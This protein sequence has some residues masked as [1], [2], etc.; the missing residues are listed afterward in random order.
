M[1]FSYEAANQSGATIIGEIEA[2]NRHEA[3][4]NLKGRG[5]IVTDIGE[6]DAFLDAPKARSNAQ[7]LLLSL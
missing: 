1:I 6:Q 4:R 3:I 7:D 5:L 2:L